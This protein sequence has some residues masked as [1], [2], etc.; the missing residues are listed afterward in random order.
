MGY[1]CHLCL[2]LCISSVLPVRVFSLF[3]GKAKS[4]GYVGG[5]KDLVYLFHGVSISLFTGHY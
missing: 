2:C 3:T 5:V 1:A 4:K